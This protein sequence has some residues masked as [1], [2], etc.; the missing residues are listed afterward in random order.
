MNPIDEV[1]EDYEA[2]LISYGQM[3]EEIEELERLGY[4]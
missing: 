3:N 4:M 1:I 2:G